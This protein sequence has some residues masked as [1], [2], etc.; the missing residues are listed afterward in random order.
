MKRQQLLLRSVLFESAEWLHVDPTRDWITIQKRIENEGVEFTSITMPRMH[1]ALLTSIAAGRWIPNRLWKEL[2]GRPVFL[3]EFLGFIFDFRCA[4]MPVKEDYKSISTLKIVR[5][6]LLL[7]SKVKVLPSQTRSNAAINGFFDTEQELRDSKDRILSVIRED[8]YFLRVC[9][10]LFGDLFDR[11]QQQLSQISPKHGPGQTA[12]SCFGVN[13]YRLLQSTWTSRLE[14]HVRAADHAYYNEHDLFDCTEGTHDYAVLPPKSESSM[15]ITLVPKTAKTPRIIAMEPVAKQWV[16][17]G[18]LY[19]LDSNIQKN[20][21]L[22]SVASWRDQERN[23]SLA[24]S[25][26]LDGSLATLDLSEASDRLHVGIVSAMLRNYPQL[27]GIVL[28][29]RSNKADFEGRSIFLHKFAPMGS[30]MCFAFETLAF[31]AIVTSALCKTHGIDRPDFK[32]ISRLL[33]G[34]VSVYGDDIIVPTDSV[35]T[36]IEYLEAFGLKVNQSKSF[37]TGLFRESCGGDYYSGVDISIQRLRVDPIDGIKPDGLVSWISTQ[38]QLFKAGYEKT[39]LWMT[40]VYKAPVH[41]IPPLGGHSYIGDTH[42]K[43]RTNPHLQKLEKQ[44]LVPMFRN[45]SL[46]GYDRELLFHWFVV[47]DHEKEFLSDHDTTEYSVRPVILAS[48]PQVV[49]LRSTFVA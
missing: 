21:L 13:K 37:W 42:A 38:N 35:N 19:L 24:C 26:S 27:R 29:S 28:A 8:P 49:R 45:Q 20:N 2:K 9:H 33:S 39:A 34:G 31:L 14:K 7:N 11:C 41:D 23:R 47:R 5:Q 15:K 3:Q 36:V 18:L 6:I 17:Q 25:G 46:L 22:R 32:S 16:Q 40:K 30:A 4:T 1:D 10:V 43:V 44:A 48:R 12:E